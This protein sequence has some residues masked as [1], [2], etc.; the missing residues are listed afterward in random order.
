VTYK[1]GD[2]V[3]W[4]G[5]ASGAEGEITDGPFWGALRPE[6]IRVSPSGTAAYVVSFPDGR[7]LLLSEAVL[8]P[9]ERWE[10][11]PGTYRQHIPGCQPGPGFTWPYQERLVEP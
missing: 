9:V 3:R 11:A 6:L 8:E 10:P 5:I 1:I 2:K 7:A 4:T